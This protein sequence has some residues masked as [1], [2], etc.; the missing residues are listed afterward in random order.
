MVP[1]M[2][3][4]THWGSV[5]SILGL[6]HSDRKACNAPHAAEMT[7]QAYSGLP[8]TSSRSDIQAIA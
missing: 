7:K 6:I 2:F 1:Y 3:P 4:Y 5:A 8:A